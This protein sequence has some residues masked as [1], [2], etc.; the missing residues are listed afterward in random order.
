MVLTRLCVI[1]FFLGIVLATACDKS[2]SVQFHLVAEFAKTT[3]SVAKLFR[4]VAYRQVGVLGKK[5]QH[6]REEDVWKSNRHF[7]ASCCHCLSLL[8]FVFLSGEETG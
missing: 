8:C 7:G 4:Y 3:P 2:T 6:F 1:A 5:G